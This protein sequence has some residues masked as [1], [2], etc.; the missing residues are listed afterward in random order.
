MQYGNIG[1][2][3]GVFAVA[4]L[5]MT[6]AGCAAPLRGPPG[7]ALPDGEVIGA[8]TGGAVTQHERGAGGLL[9]VHFVDV[10]QGD[11]VVWELPG[12]GFLVYDCGPP[13]AS[14]QGNPVVRA[15]HALGLPPGGTVHALVAS[16]GH[17]DHVGGCEEV[18]QTFRVLHVYD[19]WYGGADAPVSYRRFQ[20]QVKAEGATVHALAGSAIPEEAVPFQAGDL[21][22]LPGEAAAAGVRAQVLWPPALQRG[23]WEDIA[24]SSVVVRLAFGDT[25]FCFQGDIEHAQEDAIVASGLEVRCDVMLAGHHGSRHAT[26]A[27]WL[28]KVRPGHVVVSFGNNSYGHPTAEALCRLQEAGAQV[29][30]TH[31]LGTIVAATDE[32]TLRVAPA[33]PETADYCRPGADYWTTPASRQG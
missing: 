21:L 13:V 9:R 12:G 15:L 23:S 26:G 3:E 10:G 11:G 28:A 20:D 29:Y 16:H 6:L 5:A 32:A 22:A 25:S 33:Q 18:L 2:Q 4:V 1:R 27:S 31:R 8:G 7:P 14:A 30:A 19:V 24:L 17:L